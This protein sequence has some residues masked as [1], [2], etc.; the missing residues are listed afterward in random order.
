MFDCKRIGELVGIEIQFS[1]NVIEIERNYEKMKKKIE[2]KY[3]FAVKFFV[4][5]LISFYSME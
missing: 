2:L 1:P 5:I 3:N 4:C